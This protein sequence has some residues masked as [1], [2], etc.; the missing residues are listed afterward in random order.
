M[1][2]IDSSTA[3]IFEVFILYKYS[4]YHSTIIIITITISTIII[5]IFAINF[6]WMT[7]FDVRDIF[8][9]GLISS[10]AY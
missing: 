2:H 1:T 5:T 7:D 8:E 10:L 3:L 9:D 4:L 6:L